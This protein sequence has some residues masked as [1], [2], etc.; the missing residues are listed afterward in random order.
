MFTTILLVCAVLANIALIVCLISCIKE[1][2]KLI[3]IVKAPLPSQAEKKKDAPK[4]E[5]P[6]E[7][8]DNRANNAERLFQEGIQS[9]LS[10]DVNVM[11]Q[12]LKGVEDE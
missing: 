6:N 10:Y 12:Y 3:E 1:L 5:L 2:D 11:K 9:I 4:Q 8:V 7:E